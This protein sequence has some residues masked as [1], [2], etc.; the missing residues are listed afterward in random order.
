METGAITNHIDV[1]QLV[2]YAFWLFFAGLIVY[3]H[4]EDKREGYPLETTGPNPMKFNGFPD[5]PAPKTF[6]LPHGGGSVTVPRDEDPQYELDADP[7]APYAGAPLHPRGDG[8]GKGVGPGAYA[9]RSETPDLTFDGKPRIVPLRVATAHRLDER[10]PNPIG[11]PVLGAD[12][13]QAATVI[14]AWV[15]LAE[16][17][18]RYLEIDVAGVLTLLPTNFSRIGRDAVRVQSLLSTQFGGLPALKNPDQVTLA[19]E[20]IIT[21]Y[22][23][24]GTLY[25]TAERSEPLI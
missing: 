8:I 14:D 7:I 15:D 4:K 16:P 5:L 24:S 10:D 9:L 11:L 17:H 23:G 22:Y 1:A 3:L 13:Q 21:A 19:E 25:A 6:T 20:D 2:L 18:V 12:G